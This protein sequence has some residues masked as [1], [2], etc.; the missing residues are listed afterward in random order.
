MVYKKVAGILSDIL[1]L[2]EEDITPDM[3]LTPEF[4]VEKI[5]I[6]KLVIE[7]EKKFKISIHDE[8]VH[9]L[10][11]VKDLVKHIENLLTKDEGN[12]SE[13]SDEERMSW[14]YQ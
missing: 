14:Y 10:H 7:C 9:E 12:L 5:H 6:A 4:E 8:K 13:S 1:N 11:T 2:D 3:G